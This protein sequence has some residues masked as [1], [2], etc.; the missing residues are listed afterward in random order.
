MSNSSLFCFHKYGKTRKMCQLLT[1]TPE[2]LK[3]L[4]E[5]EDLERAENEEVNPT[6]TD[7]RELS[8]SLSEG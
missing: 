2:I 8:E 4:K 6:V 7:S 5:A 1:E 3:V